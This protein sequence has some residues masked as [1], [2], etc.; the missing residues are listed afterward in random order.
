MS[1]FLSPTCVE[2]N[3]KAHAVD[4][5]DDPYREEV[6]KSP[7]YL[8]SPR[9]KIAPTPFTY[10]SSPVLFPM[11]IYLIHNEEQRLPQSDRSL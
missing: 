11:L 5:N 6:N 3:Q 9:V 2:S 4:Y 8:T 1:V 7:S 10:P